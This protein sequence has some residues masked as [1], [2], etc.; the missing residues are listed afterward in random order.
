MRILIDRVHTLH[1]SGLFAVVSL[2]DTKGISPQY[3]RLIEPASVPP[4]GAAESP[5]SSTKSRFLVEGS[6]RDASTEASPEAS[7]D[8]RHV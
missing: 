2:I 6:L 1:L 4:I 7:R 8:V 3:P 5:A